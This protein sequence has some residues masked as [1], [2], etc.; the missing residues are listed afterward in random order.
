[1]AF[2]GLTWSCIEFNGLVLLP[3]MAYYGKNIDLIE[4]ES[5]FLAVI[6]PNSCGLVSI[7]ICT[8]SLQK[9]IYSK[10]FHRTEMSEVIESLMELSNNFLEAL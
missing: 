6:D 4:L 2:Y 10:I 7:S 1:M 3:F 5:P 9:W 8:V